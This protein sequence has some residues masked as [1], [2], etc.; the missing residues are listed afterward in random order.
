[1]DRITTGLSRRAAI[2]RAAA[3][4]AAGAAPAWAADDLAA[5]QEAARK[6]GR[7]SLYHNLR[8]QGAEILL[9]EFRKANPG[10]QTEHIR[11]GSAPLIE[12]FATEFNAGRNL[13]DVVITF[14][15]DTF[16]AGV[17]KGGWALEWTPPELAAFKPEVNRGNR[18]FAVHTGR[19]VII[20]N[21]Q[22]VK[23]AD[24]PKEWADLWDPKWKGRVGMDP[25]WRSVAVQSIVAFWSKNGIKDAAQKFKDNDVRFFEGSA[26]VYQAVLRGDVLVATLTDLPVEPGLEDGAPI[27]FVYPKSGTTFIDG[28]LFVSAKAPHRAAGQVLANWLMTARGQEL[29][30]EHDGLPVTRPGV[31]PP[32]HVPPTSNLSNAID[33]LTIVNGP[34]QQKEIETWRAVFGIR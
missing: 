7:V 4:M 10:I 20:W 21:K 8:P 13:A 22:R 18:A 14:P 32:K 26:G 23:P 25:P 16:F 17:D 31:A 1:M 6:E 19:N 15:D 3:L 29:L 24:A 11:L 12:R 28:Y 30:Q 33:A 2:A 9:A 5:L 34:E 27:G